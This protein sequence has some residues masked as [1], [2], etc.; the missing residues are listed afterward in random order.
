MAA[1]PGLTRLAEALPVVLT[2]PGAETADTTRT[3]RP[4][5]TSVWSS[6]GVDAA[7]DR[8]TH[9][10]R[11]GAASFHIV[12]RGHADT[13]SRASQ[14][15]VYM[16][17]GDV[18]P[19]LTYT[20]RGHVKTQDLE[21]EAGFG[22]RLK[23]ESGWLDVSPRCDVIRTT[24][25]WTPITARFTTA[26]GATR[27]VLFLKVSHAGEAWFDDLEME[28]NLEPWCEQR[29]TDLH[30]K[31]SRLAVTA[32]SNLG[33][34]MLH[35]P[36]AVLDEAVATAKAWRTK[37]RALDPKSPLPL[38]QRHRFIVAATELESLVKTHERAVEVRKVVADADPD[39]TAP[40]ILGFAPSSQHV[41]LND[42]PLKIETLGASRL[43]AVGGETEATQLVILAHQKDLHAVRVTISDLACPAGVIPASSVEVRPVGFVRTKILAAANPYPREFD[44]AGWWPDPILENF[45]FDVERSTSQPIWI[46]IHVPPNMPPGDYRGTIDV[47]TAKGDRQSAT[48]TVEVAAIS[49][50][51]KWRFRN[52]LS[53][54]EHWAKQ[55]YGDRWNDALHEKFL[56]FLLDRRLNVIS[57]YGNEPYATTENLVR[58]AQKGQNVLMLASLPPEAKIRASQAVALRARLDKMIPAMRSAGVL[59]RCIVY[60]WDE[61]QPEWYDEIRYGADMLLNDYGAMPLLMAGTDPT[62]GTDSSLAGLSN[63]IYCPLMPDYD[64]ELAAQARANGNAVWWYEIWWIIEDP[65]IRSRLIPWQSFK[66]GADGFLFWCLNRFVGNAKP[67]FDPDNPKIRTDWNPALDG[68]YENSTAMYLYP[69]RDGPISS[70]RLENLRDGIEDY[71]L[72]RWGQDLAEGQ[73]VADP[74]LRSLLQRAVTLDN[75]FVTDH[76]EYTRDPAILARYRRTLIEALVK[77]ME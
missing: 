32:R 76:A 28:D 70:L 47:T 10:R 24:R 66:V 77:A 52:L 17:E 11:S 35:G 20:V 16:I 73:A 57:M 58:F 18:V 7:F 1:T 59:D 49:L 72:L 56:Q 64:A 60:G 67:V 71:E 38:G 25:D 63:I 33:G 22:I 6:A 48:L 14:S 37:A 5:A 41:F 65:L 3:D 53:W 12:S 51:E 69:G 75:S 43:L 27:F 44:H 2:N 42:L 55:F 68:G 21:S 4:A 54:H 36:V 50:P 19:G 40:F 45:A 29:F 15:A 23:S 39:G 34:A 62:C 8:D 26:P 9:I 13:A 46:A 74:G 30:E 61:R 31:L